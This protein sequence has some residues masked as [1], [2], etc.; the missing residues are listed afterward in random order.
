MG[1]MISFIKKRQ[2]EALER[3]EIKFLID[4]LYRRG[5]TGL[6][7]GCLGYGPSFSRG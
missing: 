4:G 2:G 3:E 6:P 1:Y 7:D 5:H